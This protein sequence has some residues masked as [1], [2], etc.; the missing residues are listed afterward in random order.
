M[1]RFVRSL[2]D[3]GLIRDLAVAGACWSG[4]EVWGERNERRLIEGEG[5]AS[6]GR[7]EGV[8]LVWPGLARWRSL[9]VSFLR[10]PEG[11]GR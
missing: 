7:G 1:E 10:W 4:G 2:V 11:H 5:R 3:W 8:R 9:R 6:G